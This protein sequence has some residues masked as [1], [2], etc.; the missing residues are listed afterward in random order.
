MYIIHVACTCIYTPTCT[1]D[2]HVVSL[3]TVQVFL[4]SMLFSILLCNQSLVWVSI[5]TGLQPTLFSFTKVHL[6]CFYS[7]CC[8]AWQ[9]SL[10]YPSMWYTVQLLRVVLYCVCD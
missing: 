9:L 5:L 8:L 3:V 1:C 6:F 10:L 4:E 7:L 2:I